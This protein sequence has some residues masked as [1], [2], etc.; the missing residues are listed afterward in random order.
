MVSVSN[1]VVLNGSGKM[2]KNNKKM[3]KICLTGSI[4]AGK[5]TIS[6]LFIERGVPV[7]NS[8]LA[9]REAEKDQDIIDGYKKILGDDIFIDG[10]LDRVRMRDIIFNDKI[11]IKMV[12]DLVTPYVK[13]KFE[14]FCEENS[15]SK[16]V[17]LEAAILFELGVEEDFDYI[18]CVTASEKT[19][20]S[21]V[22]R[23]DNVSLDVVMSKIN[24]QLPEKE[25]ITKSDFVIINDGDDL[26]DSLDLLERQVNAVNGAICFRV[27]NQQMLKYGSF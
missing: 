6:K 27:L 1:L 16:I 14:L 26:L 23:R 20:I 10:V 2:I 3:I 17:M 18:I 19:R 9:A 12:N 25:K 7:F 24:N 21:R 8:D 4:G 13:N 22:L 11:K 15:S 5:S